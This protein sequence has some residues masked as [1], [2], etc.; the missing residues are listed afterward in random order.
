MSVNTEIADKMITHSV[1]LEKVKAGLLYRVIRFLKQLEADLLSQLVNTDPTSVSSRYQRKRL[2]SLLI[3]TQATIKQ[4]YMTTEADVREELT[5]LAK[6]QEQAVIRAVNSS[7]AVSL[8]NTLLTAEQ[9]NGLLD[10]MLIEGAPS[11]EWWQRQSESLRRRF[12]D[13]MRLGVSQGEALGDLVRRVRGTR[14]N[15]FTDGIMTVSRRSAEALV[16]TSAQKIAV[17]T[18]L[19]VFEANVNVLKAVQQ[20]STLDSRTTDICKAYSGLQWSLPGYEPIGH[21][22]PFNGG[23]PRHWSCRS[24]I[25]P[26]TKSWS[27]L[28][29][30]NIQ[31]PA[32]GT[33]K[34]VDRYFERQ[35][36][37]K[38]LSEDEIQ[39]TLR[40]AQASMD[41]QVSQDLNYEDW[42]RTKDENFQKTIL[43]DVKYRLW[44]SNKITFR[45]LVDESGDPMSIEELKKKVGK[46]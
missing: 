27:E 40:R 11:G 14:K 41:G 43:G 7:V 37:K 9:L 6:V 33:S 18:N 31:T 23:T 8:F 1:D 4:A 28:S 10:S 2:E 38:G 13:Q 3:Q 46:P 34:G 12:T 36:R 16:R 5:Q 17:Q 25:I 30:S 35:L 15:G 20:R 39:R 19:A 24:S 26:V 45:D 32:G 29:R 44:K 22:L 42:L 21:E